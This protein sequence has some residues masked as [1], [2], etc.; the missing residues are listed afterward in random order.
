MTSDSP[1]RTR[2]QSAPRVLRALVLVGAC[3]GIVT[4]GMDLLW[5]TIAAA[6]ITALLYIWPF[7]ERRTGVR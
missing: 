1:G 7:G 3:V 4:S 5:G 2:A 6:G